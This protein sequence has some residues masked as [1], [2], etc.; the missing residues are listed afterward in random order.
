[1]IGD[2]SLFKRADMIETGWTV[3]QPILD[4]WAAGRGG[5]LDRYAAGSEGPLAAEDMIR[6]DGRVWRPF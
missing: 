1:M 4:A 6:G 5:A 3:I 2:A